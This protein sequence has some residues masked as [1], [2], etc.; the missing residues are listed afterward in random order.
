VH[1]YIH[2]AGTKDEAAAEL[3]R[4]L[5]EPVLAVAGGA[6]ASA[7]LGIIRSHKV[8]DVGF[9]ETGGAIGE[10]LLV[11]EEREA[12]AGFYPEEPGI[13][14][15]PQADRREVCALVFESLFVAAQLRDVLPA[16]DSAVM[17]QEHEDGGVLFPEGAQAELQTVGVGQN[18]AGKRLAEGADHS[19]SQYK[20]WTGAGACPTLK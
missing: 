12:D 2:I 10:A 3:E 20:Q 8:Q 5:A 18:D 16:E 7:G 19:T 15:V 13:G 1:V 4:I 6:G 11:D 14:A 17:P 9:S